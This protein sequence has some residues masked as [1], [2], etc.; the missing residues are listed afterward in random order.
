MPASKVHSL[1][2]YMGTKINI[3]SV[4]LDRISDAWLS[5]N[6]YYRCKVGSIGTFRLKFEVKKCH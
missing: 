2:Y 6:Q 1:N 3:K 4:P 5:T